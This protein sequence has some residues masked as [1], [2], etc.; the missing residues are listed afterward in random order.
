[1]IGRRVKV[2]ND[3]FNGG[4]ELWDY[5]DDGQGNWYGL[6]PPD[7]MACMTGHKRTEH[8][9]GTVTFSPSILTKDGQGHEWH[10]YLEKGVWR[11]V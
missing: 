3:K 4:L 11:Q 8:E 5:G 1:M 10:G 7:M 9:D 6:V 2:D